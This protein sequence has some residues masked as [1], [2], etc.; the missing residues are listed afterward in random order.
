MNSAYQ[1]KKKDNAA[2][3]VAQDEKEQEEKQA[4]IDEMLRTRKEQEMSGSGKPKVVQPVNLPKVPEA[5]TPLEVLARAKRALASGDRET[6]EFP[7]DTLVRGTSR[8][9]LVETPLSWQRA[10]AFA[11]EHG[12]HLA[13]CANE[14]EQNWLSS[15]IPKGTTV[16][17][18]GGT[19]SRAAWG[20]VDGTEWTLR[21]PATSTGTCAT[22]SDLGTLRA[23][24][25]GEKLPFYIQWNMDGSNPGKLEAQLNRLKET[26][27]SPTPVYPPG[28]LAYENRR[29]L[30]IEKN[31][32]WEE[33]A[34]IARSAHWSPYLLISNWL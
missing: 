18:G 31:V 19:T 2:K 15:K 21:S 8:F 1:W 23:K 26:M 29:Y 4:K 20:W 24:V 12:G 33:A 32:G 9:F 17:L 16:W 11:E 3:T 7:P 14:T 10:A 30:I 13:T 5:E 6:G 34:G 28:V 22:L 25:G 27:G